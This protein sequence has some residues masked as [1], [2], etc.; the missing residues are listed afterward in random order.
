M[1][2]D[3]LPNI[4][5]TVEVQII[6]MEPKIPFEETDAIKA[7]LRQFTDDINSGNMN[8]R[9]WSVCIRKIRISQRGGELGFWV[10]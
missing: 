10:R 2:K 7:R 1:S 4:P 9:H 5:T 8:F 3:S 6:T